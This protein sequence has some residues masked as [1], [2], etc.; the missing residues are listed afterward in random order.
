MKQA[1][2]SKT[3]FQKRIVLENVVIPI[4]ITIA[5]FQPELKPPRLARGGRATPEF[6]YKPPL[7]GRLF[8]FDVAIVKCA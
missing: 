4:R 6:A 3:L 8:S 7:S 5:P 1:I 2:V